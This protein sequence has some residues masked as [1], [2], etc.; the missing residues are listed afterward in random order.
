MITKAILQGPCKAPI[1]FSLQGTLQA[2][3]VG[4]GNFK[5]GDTWIAF[6]NVNFLTVSGFGVFDGQGSSAWGQKCDHTEFCGN[7]PIVSFIFN[8]RKPKKKKNVL[9]LFDNKQLKIKV[10]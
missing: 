5:G 7:L 3:P 1:E 4:S 9:S 2:P 8:Y 6:D 10:N